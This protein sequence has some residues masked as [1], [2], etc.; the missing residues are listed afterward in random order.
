MC[1]CSDCDAFD[2]V[3]CHKASWLSLNTDGEILDPCKAG[4]NMSLKVT[5][6][7]IP[8]LVDLVGDI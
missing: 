3:M 8:S 4:K 2:A 5:C 7:N 6:S 1:F